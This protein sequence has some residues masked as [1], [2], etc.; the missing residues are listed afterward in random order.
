MTRPFSSF[1]L[2]SVASNNEKW[3]GFT[4]WDRISTLPLRISHQEEQSFTK[5]Q[6][7]GLY[8]R[9]HNT[10]YIKVFV[11]HKI[12]YI[13]GLVHNELPINS[14]NHCCSGKKFLA[15]FALTAMGGLTDSAAQQEKSQQSRCSSPRPSGGPLGTL[16]VWLWPL[17]EKHWEEQSPPR[18]QG[19]LFCNLRS[20]VGN[21]GE[22]WNQPPNTEGKERPTKE[23]AILIGRWQA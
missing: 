14:M 10:Y 18:G 8:K 2:Y 9:E 23:Q 1:S 15:Q 22:I 16:L 13:W 19:S 4:P 12:V 7:P 20:L 21:L 5:Y 11:V 3:F 6:L 17:G